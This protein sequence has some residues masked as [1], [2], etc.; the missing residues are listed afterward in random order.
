MIPN[1][2]HGVGAAPQASN[3]DLIVIAG[4]VLALGIAFIFQKSVNLRVGI[5]MVVLG[6]GGVVAGLTVFN[7]ANQTAGAS[8]IITVQGQDYPVGDLTDAVTAMCEASAAA[9]DGE[10]PEART[11]FIDRA[12]VPLHV[13]AAAV[14]DDDRQQAAALLEAKQLVETSITKEGI[15]PEKL[16]GYI[17]RLNGAT[18]VAL[19]T[20]GITSNAC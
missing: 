9:R 8:E 16:A 6:I 20:L 17:D 18:T 12:H 10:V 1:L 2:A 19:A 13:I 14:E 11:I 7:D 3:V 4:G 15:D 5:V